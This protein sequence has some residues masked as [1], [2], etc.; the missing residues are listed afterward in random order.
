MERSLVPK[1]ISHYRILHPLGAGGMGE[2]YLA[3]DTV[4][5]RQVAI[6]FL[7]SDR[8][9]DETARKRL[10]R[11]ARAAARLDHPNICSVYEVCE[12]GPAAFIV[13]QYVEGETLASKL[14]RQPL[15]LRQALDVA[16]QAADALAE[17]HAHGVVHRDVKP[18]NIMIAPG[19]QV[20]LMDFGLAVLTESIGT[21]G[22]VTETAGVLTD[23]RAIAGTVAY[24]SPEQA[25]GE[26]LDVRS[27]IFSFGS[28]LYEAICGR[29][30]FGSAS[31]AETLS[32]ILTKQPAP[33]ADYV[34]G[35]H[36]EVE[37]IV[38]KC[39]EKDLNRRYQSAAEL[40]IDLRRLKREIEGGDA[41]TW[42]R[43][44]GLRPVFALGRLAWLSMAILAVIASMVYLR[45]C[46]PGH[47]RIESLAVLPFANV[48]ADPD[49]DY[50]SDGITESLINS[51]ARLPSLKVKSRNS[52]FG[53]R[54]RE[55]DV[56]AVAR[57]L[58]VRAVL[59]GRVAQRGDT[60]SIN[61]ALVDGSDG[62]QI[63]GDQF[64]RS[65]ADIL[66]LQEDI[67]REI[68]SKLRPQLTPGEQELVTRRYTDDPQAYRLYL[69]GRYHWSKLSPEGWRK[70]TEYFQ[71]AIDQ[72]PTYAL[73]YAGLAD[74][75]NLRGIFSLIPPRDGFP[76][77]KQ[78]ATQAL[79]ID[80][81]LAEAHSS[82]GI[83][84]FYFDWDWPAAER[85]FKRAIELNSDY[86]YA[87]NAY[88]V[89]L[90][91]M[92]RFD[93]A[94]VQSRRAE[95]LE[96]L[97]TLASTNVALVLYFARR[98][99]EAILQFRKALELDRGYFTAHFWLGNTYAQ[100]K[101]YPDAIR[102]LRDALEL[103]GGQ[104][105]AVAAL[106]YAHAL[107]GDRQEAVQMLKRLTEL[108][109]RQYV[110]PYFLALVY[111]LVGDREQTFEWLERAFQERSS[112]MARL[113]V[114][115]WM[116]GLSSD[117]RFVSL[118]RR[119]GHTP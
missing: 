108:G 32:A 34:G 91:A 51:L 114:E 90:A 85:E 39:L 87:H 95:E 73:A 33:L 62:S 84:S 7:R 31:L 22:E 24:M 41:A 42:T 119:V 83:A 65:S 46:G 80:E 105:V 94:I 54:G 29:P 67:F 99:E 11:E 58:G 106:G 78:A 48:S 53:Y 25:R 49:A 76:K 69:R 12:D 26:P 109:R 40:S 44:R 88:G 4:L 21:T 110:S 115:P 57:E 59:T 75:Y 82:L 111:Q 18:Q 60:V 37:R 17:A 5:K 72:D 27:D 19:G 118:L 3:E 104:P 116:D 2:V 56:Q 117:P 16:A 9:V 79:E 43:S 97:S 38:R 8:L 45:L 66:F 102:E 101:M 36:D 74:C 35:L 113:K 30:A 28:T 71:Q 68:S 77:A 6:K 86:S 14:Q 100:R 63:W 50:L 52:V 92:G 103:S 20:K 112:W 81:R 47:A 15:P 93:E 70:G 13:M 23:P 1:T 96:P 10:T 64:R 89:Y 55:T 98:P 107:S 61:V